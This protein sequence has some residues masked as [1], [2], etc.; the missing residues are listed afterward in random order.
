MQPAAS[1]CRTGDGL[2][3]ALGDSGARRCGETKEPDDHG[4]G[5]GVP[6][7]ATSRALLRLCTTWP[8][9]PHALR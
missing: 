6:G 1:D 5:D 7:D 3:K 2:R 8:R 9:C 4:T